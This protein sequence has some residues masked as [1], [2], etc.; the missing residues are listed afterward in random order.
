MDLAKLDHIPTVKL[1]MT[2]FP[3]AVDVEAPLSVAQGMMGEH[4]VHQLPVTEAGR[5]VGVIFRRDV[6]L[7]TESARGRPRAVRV[8][9]AFTSQ[10]HVV[11]DGERLDGV[12]ERMAAAHVAAALVVRRGKL[13]GIFT[14]TDACRLFAEWLRARFPDP[15]D[16]AAA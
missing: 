15:E 4:G 10:A 11:E 14:F 9:D 5:L 13:V 1:A 3:H 16:G 12:L 2:P 7:A 8:R 6:D